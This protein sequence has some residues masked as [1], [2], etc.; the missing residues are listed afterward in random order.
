MAYSSNPGASSRPYFFSSVGDVIRDRSSAVNVPPFLRRQRLPSILLDS[1]AFRK[2]ASEGSVLPNA[3]VAWDV[4]GDGKEEVI[5]G[6]TEGHVL[7]VK[8]D[9]RV[10]IFTRVL[11]ATI[12][13]VLYS[14]TH[15]RLVLIT[16]EGK[17]EVLDNFLVPVTPPQ[18]AVSNTAAPQATTAC[19][20]TNSA[21]PA[22][23]L[24]SATPQNSGT[25]ILSPPAAAAAADPI[26]SHNVTASAHAEPTI[27]NIF[28]IPSNCIC[29]AFAVD[30]PSDRVFLGSYDRRLYI[31]MLSTGECL[32]SVF[33]HHPI[34]CVK[35][36][37]VPVPP[38]PQSQSRLHSETQSPLG[39]HDCS[40]ASHRPT[41]SPLKTD[42][43]ATF[44]PAAAS[45][46]TSSLDGAVPLVFVATPQSIV[47]L[48][49]GVADA[50][51]WRRME[52][53]EK[54]PLSIVDPDAI[55]RRGT[56][57]VGSPSHTTL[58][59]AAVAS[60]ASARSAAA[61]M[62][63]DTN[64]SH[65][66]DVQGQNNSDQETSESSATNPYEDPI[67]EAAQDSEAHATTTL[68]GVASPLTLIHPLWWLNL[69]GHSLEVLPVRPPQPHYAVASSLKRVNN[70]LDSHN[71]RLSVGGAE[72]APLSFE[73]Q[74]ATS[75]ASSS[76]SSTASNPLR[77]PLTLKS[78][79]QP[80]EGGVGAGRLL[81]TSLTE[82]PADSDPQVMP[83]AGS[84]RPTLVSLADVVPQRQEQTCSPTGEK[85]LRCRHP[86]PDPPTQLESTVAGAVAVPHAAVSQ[87]VYEEDVRLPIAMDVTVMHLHVM[88]AVGCEDGR[89]FVLRGVL[90][91]TEP[92][93]RN[94]GRTS[95]RPTHRKKPVTLV[96]DPPDSRTPRT[97]SCRLGEQ[98]PN[99]RTT[100]F[101]FRQNDRVSTKKRRTRDSVLTVPIPDV[102]G[103]TPVIH[104][105]LHR[106]PHQA[107]SG[108][109]ALS[110]VVVREEYAFAIRMSCAWGGVLTDS[111]LVRQSRIF[112]VGV[113][114][115]RAVFVAVNG[116]CYVV[117]P[118]THCSVE[119]SV[120]A[121]SSTFTILAGSASCLVP[122]FGGLSADSRGS[123]A[124]NSDASQL[125]APG[126]VPRG[127]G[128]RAI[129]CVCVSVDEL[130]IYT[131]GESFWGAG[132][133]GTT[134]SRPHS[135]IHGNSDLPISNSRTDTP[136]FDRQPSGE[137]VL[138]EPER[139]AGGDAEERALLLE[140]GTTLLHLQ[141]ESAT[142]EAGSAD[143]SFIICYAKRVLNRGYN[144]MD[145][146]TLRWMDR[147]EHREA[148]G[149]APL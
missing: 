79:R 35:P 5:L 10:P 30:G 60:P 127:A 106:R 54:N 65:C 147:R 103:E 34:T 50:Q 145:W 43:A 130:C 42:W 136:T 129:S 1:W 108:T 101:T 37:L 20:P 94:A 17:C 2:I 81:A 46:S 31:Y 68:M 63:W 135:T 128:D 126:P 111:P 75:R 14:E 23:R 67:R 144:A 18:T 57:P 109:K 8:P 96:V 88:L 110:E 142:R 91:R 58:A 48:P 3:L 117:D 51:A 112:R 53:Q 28:H 22:S 62:E 125:N 16:L 138:P 134:C 122:P 15:R 7:V 49:G 61:S 141:P 121:D 4:D 24:P 70:L 104:K 33:M 116:A 27:T 72:R 29:A 139:E 69:K 107:A 12:S 74:E 13:T 82:L 56:S 38:A 95:P 47:L 119:C 59:V 146:E 86:Q 71:A 26:R 132:R 21:P 93:E 105:K 41:D 64:S 87:T 89:A 25:V 84:I 90:C 66:G 11:A 32:A 113:D 92:T 9:C 124:G 52:T 45:S 143:E 36:C 19:S 55:S 44:P 120:R 114:S 131:I 133:P 40:N 118:D 73:D 6:T 123:P 39:R 98:P 140:L 102:S 148:E 77:V 149:G 80:S 99:K 83:R 100:L 97:R 76:A 115:F 78:P 85:L 137:Y